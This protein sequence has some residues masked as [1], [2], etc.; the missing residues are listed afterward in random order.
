LGSGIPCP[1]TFDGSSLIAAF[2]GDILVDIVGTSPGLGC[3]GCV[4]RCRAMMVL[5]LR[6]ARGDVESRCGVCRGVGSGCCAGGCYLGDE[7]G[8]YEGRYG[9]WGCECEVNEQRPANGRSR[10]APAS[11]D[12]GI[13][14]TTPSHR[15][16]AP[17]HHHTPSVYSTLPSS[18]R[19]LY[20]PSLT[21]DRPSRIGHPTSRPYP[22]SL[23]PPSASPKPVTRTPRDG[24]R[25]PCRARHV[26]LRSDPRGVVSPLHR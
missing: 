20:L 6:D 17:G 4:S 24:I 11:G 16:T 18:H 5:V 25:R 15:R 8:R 1:P 23:R 26:R 12:D 19:P 3:H 13:K 21:P 10:R 14:S 9:G 7:R 2:K 22:S